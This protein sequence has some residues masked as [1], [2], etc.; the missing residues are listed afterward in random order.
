[1]LWEYNTRPEHF[2]KQSERLKSRQ[3]LDFFASRP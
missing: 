1:L 3:M 2:L